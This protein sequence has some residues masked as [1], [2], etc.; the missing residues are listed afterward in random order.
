MVTVVLYE[1]PAV[2]CVTVAALLAWQR[3]E[4]LGGLG[5]KEFART[6]G[7]ASLRCT[8]AC[9]AGIES[10]RYKWLSPD[11]A[12]VF[13]I[14]H[15]KNLRWILN[16]GLHCRSADVQD[17]DFE[18]IGHPE[19]INRRDGATVPV[20]PGGTLSDYIPFYFTPFSPMAL[21]IKSGHGVPSV[22]SRDIA[23]LVASLHRLA[24]ACVEFVY[25]DRH[26]L[27]DTAVFL[28]SL[29][30]LTHIDWAGLRSRDFSYDPADPGRSERYQA[31]ALVYQHL[32]LD[33]LEGILCH[34]QRQSEVI[35]AWAA[36]AGATVKVR[37]D[38]EYYI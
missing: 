33:C 30:D 7:P 4:G 36:D 22:P 23:I 12:Y 6:T 38:R 37:A 18:A 27:L 26:A 31:E 2:M 25:T 24:E 13:R 29:H 19:I 34:G 15:I 14:T 8:G 1:L 17:P 10:M 35:E 11:N 16:H 28:T 20:P 21:K 5:Y 9:P 3:Q 32:P